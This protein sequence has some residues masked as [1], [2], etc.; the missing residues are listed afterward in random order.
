MM[1]A[2][3]MLT[4]LEAAFK[5]AASLSLRNAASKAGAVILGTYHEG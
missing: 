4:P 3:T 2:T 1:V 5:V